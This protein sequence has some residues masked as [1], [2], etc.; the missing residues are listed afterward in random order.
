MAHCVCGL[1]EAAVYIGKTGLVT[2]IANRQ[3]FCTMVESR[4]HFFLGCAKI[5]LHH[6]VPE[7]QHIVGRKGENKKH[8]SHLK[9]IFQKNCDRLDPA[10]F[11]TGLIPERLWSR[12]LE[13][14]RIDV[15]ETR[16]PCREPP[17]IVFD[18]EQSFVCLKGLHRLAAAKQVFESQERWWTVNFFRDG[19]SFQSIMLCA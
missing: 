5:D 1:E 13:L 3:F 16:D 8:I 10:N 12:A 17:R 4:A 9:G 14:Q 11:I 2:L 19:M 18:A 7:L 6:M 15:A